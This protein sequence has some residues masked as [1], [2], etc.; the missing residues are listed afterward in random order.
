M[1][2]RRSV[3]VGLWIN[4]ANP[5]HENKARVS[6]PALPFERG[7]LRILAQASGLRADR[8]NV[9]WEMK[10]GA[11]LSW[12]NFALRLRPVFDFLVSALGIEPRTP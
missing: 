3:A 2:R 5:R 9:P 11:E 8:T 4:G 10:V 7:C 1:F 12:L 6:V